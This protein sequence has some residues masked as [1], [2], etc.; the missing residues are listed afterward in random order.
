M[1]LR[2][3]LHRM[4]S[5]RAPRLIEPILKKYHLEH[6]ARAFRA[7]LMPAVRLLCDKL[8]RRPLPPGRSKFGG[9]PDLHWSEPWPSQEGRPL[10][11]LAQLRLSDVAHL[12]PRGQLPAS[13]V[14][15]LWYNSLGERKRAERTLIDG[16]VF[17]PSLVHLTFDPD[18]SRP[19]DRRPW[20]THVER[21]RSE[22]GEPWSPHRERAMKFLP[23]RSVTAAAIKRVIVAEER[24]D[25]ANGWTRAMS[26]VREIEASADLRRADHKLLGDIVELQTDSRV[27][28]A[29]T[30]A[31]VNE[32]GNRSRAR[33][34]SF[35]RRRAVP[36]SPPARL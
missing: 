26:A 4:P 3:K 6:H 30:A 25:P 24:V 28:A 16:A 34:A 33:G 8:H 23:I 36:A 17:E 18:E 12:L 1:P 2:D 19:L 22:F 32:F 27:T 5:P 13:G 15:R 35:P 10:H 7:G 29:C 20:P 31:G 11:F 9:E 21:F 14:L